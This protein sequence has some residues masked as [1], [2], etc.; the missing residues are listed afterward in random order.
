MWYALSLAFNND[1]NKVF[2][3]KNKGLWI[4]DAAT[5]DLVQIKQFE[6]Y[7]LPPVFQGNETF[8]AAD[9]CLFAYSQSKK[10]KKGKKV[11]SDAEKSI[12][13]KLMLMHISSKCIPFFQHPL[14]PFQKD[15]EF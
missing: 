2:L 6:D 8:V 14:V 5:G 3:T 9:L 4:F 7:V 10:I 15:S 13:S 1:V 11:T 12:L